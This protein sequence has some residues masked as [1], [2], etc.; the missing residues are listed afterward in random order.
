MSKELSPEVVSDSLVEVP[1][2]SK[3][4]MLRY[5]VAFMERLGVEELDMDEIL[6]QLQQDS[7]E[8]I[9]EIP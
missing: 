2:Y 9:Q 5:I 8:N 1:N 6:V 4:T 7:L 3:N